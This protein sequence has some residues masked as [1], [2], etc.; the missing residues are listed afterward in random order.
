ME[1]F[2]LLHHQC[3]YQ[4]QVEGQGWSNFIQTETLGISNTLEIPPTKIYFVVLYFSERGYFDAEKI[5]RS[6][7]DA[8][9]K[10]IQ[11]DTKLWHY[12]QNASQAPSVELKLWENVI[13]FIGHLEKFL[14]ANPRMDEGQKQ[15]T[16]PKNKFPKKF[17]KIHFFLFF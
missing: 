6:L 4:I 7:Y 1:I 14:F 5:N 17:A 13:R 8:L 2:T 9:L 15:V 11:S 10:N 3:F 16:L 12:P